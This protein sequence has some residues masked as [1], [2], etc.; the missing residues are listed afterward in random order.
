MQ[1]LL[2]SV[3]FQQ[4][5]PHS[6]ATTLILALGPS[7][8][9]TADIEFLFLQE[10]LKL[11]KDSGDNNLFY[12]AD[13]KR[14]VRVFAQ[15]YSIQQDRMEPQKSAR[16]LALNSNSTSRW[17][18]LG[19]LSCIENILPCCSLCLAGLMA[20]E[21]QPERRREANCCACWS[22]EGLTHEPPKDCPV[23]ILSSVPLSLPFRKNSFESMG[24]ACDLAF[25]QVSHGVWL[26]AVAGVFMRSE[27]VIEACANMV[28]RAG[29]N[30]FEMGLLDED[31]NDHA[32]LLRLSQLPGTDYPVVQPEK[33]L[34]W[35]C[36]GV[37]LL[38][39]IDVL[40]HLMFLG[41]VATVI[42]DTFFKWLKAHGKMTSLCSVT[43]SPVARLQK[44]NID[45]CKVQPILSSGSL[46]NSVS[47]NFLAFARCGKWL[48]GCSSLLRG[49]NSVHSD[50]DIP[51]RLYDVAQVRAWYHHREITFET[52]LNGN[53][54]K[55][56]FLVAMAAPNGP[57][58]IP[59]KGEAGIS[60]VIADSLVESMACLAAHAMIGGEIGE[61]DCLALERHVKIFLSRY[62]AFDRPKRR[63]KAAQPVQPT[64]LAGF[65]K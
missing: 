65:R 17:G 1:S 38:E 29:L 4:A 40:M 61:Q 54:M 63:K 19:R 52:K 47:E 12:W 15:I 57:P 13:A 6:G 21:D 20:N 44:M 56:L 3:G 11:A 32:E 26:K 51:P 8:S 2:A 24:A 33:P 30:K 23:E 62:D 27:G 43:K 9:D 31:S 49:N 25:L 42:R 55:A 59:K 36:P 46:S 14:V 60:K 53:D 34:T 22:M 50:P 48:F 16:I 35:Q 39:C 64:R 45:W 58:A 37:T 41:V 10:L 5:D 7:G 28:V 18:W